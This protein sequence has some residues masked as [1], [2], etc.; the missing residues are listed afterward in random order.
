MTVAVTKLVETPGKLQAS[1]RLAAVQL[2]VFGL[3]GIVL[4]IPGL[5]HHYFIEQDGMVIG[6]YA[7]ALGAFGLGF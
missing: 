7:A 6:L 5:A 2:A 4:S 3:L 1:C